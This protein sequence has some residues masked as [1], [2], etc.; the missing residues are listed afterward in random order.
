MRFVPPAL[1][2]ALLLTL[3]SPAQAQRRQPAEGSLAV[4][5]DIGVFIPTDELFGPSPAIEGHADFYVSP[6][7]SVR[8]GVNWTDP[9]F[10]RESSDSLRQIRIGGDFLYNWE[11]GKW[12][13]FAGAGLAA[14]LLQHKDNGRSIGDGES[15]LGGA[16][17]GGIEYFT[18]RT[19]A[20]KGEARY[21]FV[22]E[23]RNNFDPSGFVLLGGVKA[24]F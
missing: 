22:G 13:P 24:Y 10:D 20:L 11:R 18:A 1:L 21:Q 23:T 16:L 12:H 5:G 4:G 7:L 14:H 15:K 3:P 6:R 19:I 17:L 2:A 8:F 9:S